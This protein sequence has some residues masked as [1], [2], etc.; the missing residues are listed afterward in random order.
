MQNRSP[1][2][3]SRA[4]KAHLKDRQDGRPLSTP[5]I[6]STN[7]EVETS[8]KLGRRYFARDDRVYTRFGNPTQNAA[9]EKLAALE[10]AESALVFSSGMAA[11]STSL[12]STLKP[13]DHVVAQR[14]IFAQTFTVLDKMARSFG[15]ETDFV[16][17]TDVDSVRAALRPETR[18]LYVETPSNPLLKIIDIRALG[19]IAKEKGLHLFVDGTFA[20]PYL[21]NPLE[22]GA[23][24][25]LHSGTK[26]L[27]GHSD[28]LCGAVAGD[29]SRIKEIR[30]TQIHLGGVLD[31]QAA[32]LLLRG[33]GTLA[34][35]M[36]RQCD[37]ALELAQFLE[38]HEQ[39]AAVNY[40]LLDSSPYREVAS[41]QMR[42]GGGVLS[43]EV[44]GGIEPARAFVNALEF[45][46]IA[47]SLGG[48]ETVTEIPYELDFN[49]E[50]LGED[51]A[52]TGIDSGLVRMAVGIEDLDDLK[53]DLQRALAAAGKHQAGR[54]VEA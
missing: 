32:W 45:I 43:F 41:R 18:L 14:E 13:G 6:R 51:A 40:P 28:V 46:P 33:M 19:A 37:L 3:H 29:T 23:T 17:A 42:G 31:P 47:T 50:E 49:E 5:I 39:I 38:G 7:F 54:A 52:K 25:V 20:S 21:Q 36:Q 4:A 34:V 11:I 35:R 8:E 22:L 9:A 24:L 2:F 12:L 26:Y 48:I 15:I 27:G 44:R 1:G 30:E 10:G 16:D 53:Q